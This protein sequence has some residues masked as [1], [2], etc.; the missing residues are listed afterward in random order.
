MSMDGHSQNHQQSFGMHMG[1]R[2]SIS[3]HSQP[4]LPTQPSN[5]SL[6][7]SMSHDLP[8]LDDS[9]IGMSLVDEDDA[10]AKF[11]FATVDIGSQLMSHGD[12]S[13]NMV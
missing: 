1:H 10:M 12:M 3:L 5:L 9:G 8:D 7:T 2:H 4:H 11:N 6:Q 13:V